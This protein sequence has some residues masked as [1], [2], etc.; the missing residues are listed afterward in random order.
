[1]L[2]SFAFSDVYR[3][4]LGSPSRETLINAIQDQGVR[5][6]DS[7]RQMLREDGSRVHVIVVFIDGE[8]LQRLALLGHVELIQID[9]I[10]ARLRSAPSMPGVGDP[11]A[12]A[13]ARR[14]YGMAA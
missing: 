11:G 8:V 3:V 10:S 14:V 5:N 6:G 4:M 7:L 9:N 13:Y 1:M 12:R 2:R